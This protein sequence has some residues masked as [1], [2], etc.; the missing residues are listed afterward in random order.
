MLKQNAAFDKQK[1][2]SASWLET[3]RPVERYRQLLQSLGTRVSMQKYIQAHI[4]THTTHTHTHTHHTHTHTHTHT[5]HTT[6]THT[7]TY[8]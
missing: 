7:H 6:H 5:T 4:H 8:T 1:D 2:Y 3:F